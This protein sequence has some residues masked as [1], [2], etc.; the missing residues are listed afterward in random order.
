MQILYAKI[1]TVRIMMSGSYKNETY[2][3][4]ASHLSL[5]SFGYYMNGLEVNGTSQSIGGLW[6]DLFDDNSIFVDSLNKIN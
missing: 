2:T 5:D 3:L 6:S 4:I 1:G